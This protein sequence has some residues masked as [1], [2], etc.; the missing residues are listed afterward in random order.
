MPVLVTHGRRDQIVSPSMA[1]HILR[2]C[3]TATAS[4]YETVGHA[5]FIEDAGRFNPELG[6]LVQRV[7][8]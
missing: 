1:D 3:P 4:W 8:S 6:D 7:A 2:V 5:P